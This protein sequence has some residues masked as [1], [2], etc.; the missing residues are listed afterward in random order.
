MEHWGILRAVFAGAL[1]AG[2]SYYFVDTTGVEAP[3]AVVWKGAGVALLA[4]W[5]A[6]QARDC[7]GWLIAAVMAFGALGDVLLET[8]GL[9]VGAIAFV[10]GHGLAITLYVRSRRMRLT[11]SQ[12]MLAMLVVPLSVAIA[13][14]LV[15]AA[16]TLAVGVYAFIVSAM[17]AV[18]WVSRFPRYRVGIGAMMFLV[19]DLLIFARM[20][21]LATSPIPD[22]LIWPLYFG[23]QTLIALGVTQ[24]LARQ[25]R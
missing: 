13:V 14:L 25:Q 22:L 17:A 2:A 23:G 20:G 10:V 15:P 6:M 24:T 12:R 19:S 16:D 4:V 1:I 3:I 7:E 11:A 9:T 5:C 21:P 18:A 8:S